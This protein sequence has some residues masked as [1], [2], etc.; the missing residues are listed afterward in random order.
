MDREDII[1]RQQGRRVKP[2]VKRTL[3]KEYLHF[4]YILVITVLMCFPGYASEVLLYN[5]MIVKGLSAF[6]AALIA[7]FLGGLISTLPFLILNI[8]LCV[9]KKKYYAIVFQIALMEILGLVFFLYNQI[10]LTGV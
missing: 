8:V 10:Q 6:G 4:W 1:S 2:Q 3:M 5:L 7:I 9:K